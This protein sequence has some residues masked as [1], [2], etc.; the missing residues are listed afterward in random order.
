MIAI[1]VSTKYSDLLNIIIP[2]NY[3]FFD[4]WYIITDENDIDTINVIKKYNY[5]NIIMLFYNFLNNG[6]VFN[7]GG[8]IRYCQQ[9]INKEV[10]YDGNILLLDSDIYLPDNFIM[11]KH[12][13][14]EKDAIYGPNKRYDYYTYEN[15]KNN[16]IDLDYPGSKHGHG[17]F[18]LYKNDKNKLYEESN[19]CSECDLIFL[20]HFKKLIIIND[21]VVKHLGKHGE[22]WNG[23]I[24]FEFI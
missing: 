11:A 6:K 16:I 3:K 24:K 2:Q 8:A 14:L 5:N 9:L 23:R 13:Q 1:T 15:F 7:K 19:N 21:L 22:N 12:L 17:F 4:K 18:Q 20:N 10:E